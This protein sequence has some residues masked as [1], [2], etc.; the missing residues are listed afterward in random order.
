MDKIIGV[1]GCNG[2]LGQALVNYGCVPMECD[3]RDKATI[4]HAIRE[5]A[6]AI[7]INSA[8]ITAVDECEE[9]LSSLAYRVNG[10]SV[11]NIRDVY[12]ANII[13]ISTSYVFDGKKKD[14]YVEGD[15][16]CP[17]SIYGKSKLAGEERLLDYSMPG[18][19]VVRTTTLYGGYK[20]DFV[21]KVLKQIQDGKE[22]TVPNNLYG[23]P[24]YIPH[25]AEALVYLA[26]METRP[27]I[28]NIAG[29][30]NLSRYELAIMALNVFGWHSRLELLKPTNKILGNAPR[31]KNGGL[32]TKLA[33]R[34]DVPIYTV[35]EGL[36]QM[37][38]Q[39]APIYGKVS[40]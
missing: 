35:L 29:K 21:T 16:P 40:K 39:K 6:P 13:H 37:Q 9:T 3:I 28:L 36:Q 17:I 4:V 38:I 24:T 31:P 27:K 12:Y 8:A 18:D 23:N 10:A 15:E 14:G 11:A 7:I 5:I 20:A 19:C 1:I 32:K 2:N 34:L 25:L 33:E 26:M 22:V 30:E